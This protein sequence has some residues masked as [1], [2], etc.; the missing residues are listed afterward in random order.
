MGRRLISAANCVDALKIF[1]MPIFGR[2]ISTQVQID[3][4]AWY[5]ADSSP[6]FFATWLTTTRR[7]RSMQL[8]NGFNEITDHHDQEVG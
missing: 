5:E 2:S 4:S 8:P 1:E 7:Q 3:P 6:I